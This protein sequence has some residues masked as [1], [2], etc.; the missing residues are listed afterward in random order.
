MGEIKRE[1]MKKGN[2]KIRDEESLLFNVACFAD[3]MIDPAEVP[4]QA[5]LVRFWDKAS[6]RRR[7]DEVNP[8]HSASASVKM[9]VHRPPAP[10]PAQFYIWDATEDYLE[11]VEREAHI[12]SK[13]EEDGRSVHI[14]IEKE[15]AGAGKDSARITCGR[16]AAKGFNVRAVDTKGEDKLTRCQGFASDCAA[17]NVWAVRGPHIST[18]FASLRRFTGKQ[19]G[20]DIADAGGGAYNELAIGGAGKPWF[21]G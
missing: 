1:R 21:G 13:A 6:T 8:R 19:P 15:P 10:L 18:L 4:R 11:M 14:R 5:R 7:R 12:D 9:G 3:R 16:L 17:G 2:W 20:S